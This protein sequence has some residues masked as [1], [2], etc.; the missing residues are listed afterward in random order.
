METNAVD[1]RQEAVRAELMAAASA[2]MCGVERTLQVLD[3]K[4]A[5]LVVRELLGGPKRFGELRTLL[6]DPSAK[7]LTDRLR[8]LEHHGVLTRTVHPEIPPRVVY[9]LTDKGRSLQIV[10]HAM[11]RWGDEHPD[12][13]LSAP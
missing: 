2:R 8:A 5:T 11:L 9:D 3:G 13:P 10:L 6:G 12:Q 7:T 1:Q 4:W